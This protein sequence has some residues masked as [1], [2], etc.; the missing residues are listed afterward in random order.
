MSA[1]NEDPARAAYHQDIRRRGV[2]DTIMNDR[3]EDHARLPAPDQS[4]DLRL[5]A[6][7]DP[8]SPLFIVAR[9]PEGSVILPHGLIEESFDIETTPGTVNVLKILYDVLVSVNTQH[10]A[11]ANLVFVI[12]GPVT[13]LYNPGGGLT[14]PLVREIFIHPLNMDNIGFQDGSGSIGLNEPIR[15]AL[16]RNLG[17]WGLSPKVDRTHSSLT[18]HVPGHLPWDVRITAYTPTELGYSATLWDILDPG[19]SIYIGSPDNLQIIRD[20]I[21]EL[22]DKRAIRAEAYIREAELRAEA[23]CVL[24]AARYLTGAAQ[25]LGNVRLRIELYRAIREDR[26]EQEFRQFFDEA[27]KAKEQIDALWRFH[28]DGLSTYRE[29]ILIR[30]VELSFTQQDL[31][32]FIDLIRSIGIMGIVTRSGESGSMVLDWNEL[33]NRIHEIGT[34]NIPEFPDVFAE[35]TDATLTEKNPDDYIKILDKT[36]NIHYWYIKTILKGDQ[37]QDEGRPD[38][39]HGTDSSP[40]HR[41]MR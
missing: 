19:S 29:T 15:A 17:E 38:T 5:P 39:S 8:L 35:E 41:D 32:G 20:K 12:S 10:P 27:V 9:P 14:W 31:A 28:A 22:P 1:W 11:S 34:E 13:Y 16:F 4:R 40:W 18:L 23:G 30:P 36:L 3:Q 24:E 6:G 7:N 21:A 2:T 33:G 26:V 37:D 25:I